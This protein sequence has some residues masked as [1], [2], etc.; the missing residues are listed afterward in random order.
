ML[1]VCPACGLLRPKIVVHDPPAV[2]CPACQATYP[3]PRLPLLI[4]SGAAGAGKTSTA[5]ALQGRLQGAL[6]LDSDVLWT[7]EFFEPDKWPRYF[8]LWLRMAKNLGASAGK[9]VLLAGAGLGV[10]ANLVRCVESR[11]FSEI[12]ILGL[13]CDDAVL[14][15][16]LRARPGWRGSADP[17]FIDGHLG[18]NRWFKEQ[19][20]HA[21]LPV[22]LF[23]TT[24]AGLDDTVDAVIAWA[25]KHWPGVA[26]DIPL[27]P[28]PLPNLNP[29]ETLA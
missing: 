12:R 26:M 18:F 3:S 17:G 9:P 15:S 19:S 23:D 21:E 10:P 4:L 27:H 14:A 29:M 11:Y 24:H 6:V 20:R 8:N 16:R 13:V 2:I 1:N 25:A 22:D 5:L 28:Q 7:E